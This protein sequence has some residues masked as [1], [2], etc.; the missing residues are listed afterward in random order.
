M[1]D[2]SLDRFKEY[3][4]S[5]AFNLSLSRAQV[6]ALAMIA[7][8]GDSAMGAHTYRA[9]H[10]KGLVADIRGPQGGI[11]YRL[12]PAGVYALK[13]V[14]LADLV[15]G[16]PEPVELEISALTE[17]LDKARGVA[18][19]ALKFA[20]SMQARAEQAHRAVK[21]VRRFL[22][23]GAPRPKPI[24]TLKDP[25][26]EM[27]FQSMVAALDFAEASMSGGR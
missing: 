2:N 21:V 25:C 16:D 4:T 26:P 10:H 14:R 17:S 13:L 5:G 15:Q 12:T 19:E 18:E 3:S 27:T 20:R 9:L 24:I 22:R 6:S 11:E 7:E 8:T 1:T 23:S